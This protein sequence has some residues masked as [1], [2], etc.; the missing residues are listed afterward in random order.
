MSRHLVFL[1]I[2]KILLILKIKNYGFLFKLYFYQNIFKNIINAFL[3][4]FIILEI[5][6]FK[7]IALKV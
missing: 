7:R 3:M 2:I 4:N 5:N 1:K 6:N